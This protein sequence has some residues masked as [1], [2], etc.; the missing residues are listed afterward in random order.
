MKRL[1][2]IAICLLFA[3]FVCYF[4]LKA[5]DARVGGALSGLD[6]SANHLTMR[7]LELHPYTGFHMQARVRHKGPM[8]WEATTAFLG[9]DIVSGDK[10]YFI[11]F[12]LTNPPPKQSNEFRIILIGGSGAQGWGATSN[13]RMFYSV[14]ER[15]L[16]NTTN[17]IFRVINFAMGAAT[18]Y[19]NFIALNRDAH[20][21]KPDL[22]IAYIGR[23]DFAVPIYEQKGS[24]FYCYSQE[25]QAFAMAMRGSEMPPVCKPMEWMMPNLMR[26]TSLGVG[27]KIALDWDYFRQRG[28][29]SYRKSANVVDGLP[30]DLMER[31]AVPAVV[32]ALKSI[33]RD[34]SGI[35]ILIAW[36]GINHELANSPGLPDGFYDQMLVRIEQGVSSY[37]N[38][39]WFV[40]NVHKYGVDHAPPGRL[41]LFDTHLNDA[42]HEVVGALLTRSVSQI[43]PVLENNKKEREARG[44]PEFGE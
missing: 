42:T 10:G 24:D 34:F 39:Q 18:V 29:E 11:D 19:Q 15:N 1:K 32:H 37:Y 27:M 28:A 17:A 31:Q 26:G 35:P 2:F 8:Q 14:L 30:I 33:K 44:L 16:N 5:I 25:L 23:N 20:G 3:L 21:L 4:G 38:N 9:A 36:Q 6:L 7:T 12:P 40:V 13:R 41:S 43:W 22:I